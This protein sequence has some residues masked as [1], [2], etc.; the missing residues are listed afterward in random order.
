M[1]RLRRA[2]NYGVLVLAG[3]VVLWLLS[4]IYVVD[5]QER[6]VITTFGR[7]TEPSAPPGIHYHWPWPIEDGFPVAFTEVRSLDLG[8]ERPEK[9]MRVSYLLTGDENMVQINI[10]IHY[11]ITDPAAFLFRVED[12]QTMMERL[13][14][15]EAVSILARSE[16]DD[17]LTTG[18]DRLAVDLSRRT[19]ERLDQLHS[20]IAITSLLVPDL[21]PPREVQA[22]FKDVASAREDMNRRV[23]EVQGQRNRQLPHARGQARATLEAAEAYRNETL[24]KARGEA[25]R[26]LDLYNQ[27]RENKADVRDKTYL[28]FVETVFKK[29]SVM[30]VDKNAV[31]RFMLPRQK[32]GGGGDK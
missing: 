28:D 18:R 24:S 5:S 16:V 25:Q 12:P 1:T 4:G 23:N 29:T 13:V 19:Q 21:S 6:Y 26:F 10:Q 27:S 31:K 30:V 8:F 17:L 32:S 3:L 11:R 14:E 2:V 9:E 22:S 15:A 20:G 7:V